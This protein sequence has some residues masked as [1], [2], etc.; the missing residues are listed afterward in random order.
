[1]SKESSP[2]IVIVGG[3]GGM[4]SAVARCLTKSGCRLT[5]AAAICWMLDRE[6][7]WVTGQVLGVDGGLGKVQSQ[8]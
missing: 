8:G 3:S 1:M 2:V 6:Q 5:L 7:S 4:G